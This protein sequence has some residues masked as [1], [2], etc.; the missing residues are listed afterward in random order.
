MEGAI[1]LQAEISRQ[2][3]ACLCYFQLVLATAVSLERA[4][5]CVNYVGV[6][7]CHKMLIDSLM[8]IMLTNE[9]LLNTCCFS[10]GI[11]AATIQQEIISPTPALRFY[12]VTTS[13]R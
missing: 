9:K 1:P 11:T 7:Y 12:L 2:E 8:E 6:Y 13:C 4:P 10:L 3:P 5:F